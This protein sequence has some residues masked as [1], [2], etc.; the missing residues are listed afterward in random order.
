MINNAPFPFSYDTHP[1]IQC[2]GYYTFVYINR[3][4]SSER[5]KVSVGND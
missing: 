5:D 1:Y 4:A 3:D 2:L